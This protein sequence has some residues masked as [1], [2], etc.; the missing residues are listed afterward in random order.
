MIFG[1]LVERKQ[2]DGILGKLR[3]VQ[4]KLM[5]RYRRNAQ[6][7]LI[8]IPILVVILFFLEP[9]AATLLNLLGAA[10]NW[11]VPALT[12]VFVIP[13]IWLVAWLVGQ[14]GEGH[15]NL[16]EA[17][18]SW[19]LGIRVTVLFYLFLVGGVLKVIGLGGIQESA[20]PRFVLAVVKDLILMFIIADHYC[21]VNDSPAL[22]R[23]RRLSALNPA[24]HLRRQAPKPVRP[25]T[26]VDG[27][28]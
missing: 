20:Q 26:D 6:H 9:H 8:A 24:H 3:K 5:R 15:S 13:L 7:Y 18:D 17:L 28:G 25:L 10:S 23:I 19:A 27:A 16:F 4:V 11:V 12:L 22:P 21:P 1:F 14:A 2:L